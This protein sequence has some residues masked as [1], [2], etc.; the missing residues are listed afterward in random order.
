M[1]C[2]REQKGVGQTGDERRDGR[3]DGQSDDGPVDDR[4]KLQDDYSFCFPCKS[5]KL[6]IHLQVVNKEE[7]TFPTAKRFT[8]LTK[9][10]LSLPSF[11]T[12]PQK[13]ITPSSPLAPF[14]W[15]PRLISTLSLS[16]S[17]PLASSPQF[18]L[19]SAKQS[20]LEDWVW[21]E[22]LTNERVAFSSSRLALSRALCHP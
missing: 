2:L 8:H 10:L 5:C 18:Q 14:L 3:Q 15:L 6:V 4:R 22:S 11:I 20:V 19:T 17:S 16:I 9:L 13:A 7:M 1:I 21:S 12:F